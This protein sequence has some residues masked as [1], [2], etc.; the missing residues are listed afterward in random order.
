MNGW[1]E[2]GTVLRL[3]GLTAMNTGNL[4]S[5]SVLPSFSKRK[6]LCLPGVVLWNILIRIWNMRK[7]ILNSCRCCTFLNK[8]KGNKI[9]SPSRRITMNHI[10]RLTRY[11]A[12]FVDEL[13]RR[14]ITDVVIS[15]GSRSTPLAM[16]FTEHPSIKEWVV[17]DERSAAFFALGLAKQSRR[18]VA[19]VCTSGTAAATYFPAV[20]EAYHSRVPLIVLTADRPHEL[21]DIGAPQAIDQIKLF[22]GFVKWYHEMALP[23]ASATMLTYARNRAAQAVH[24]AMEEN[25]GPVHLNLPFREPLTPD[26]TLD[27][28]WDPVGEKMTEQRIT[29]F[30]GKKQLSEGAISLLLRRLKEYK[31]G[32]IVCG[33]QTDPEFKE[34]VTALAEQWQIPVLADPLSQVRCGS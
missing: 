20:V 2:G 4:L 25:Q 6:H 21:R 5:Q 15:P 16:M 12:N 31:K 14:G 26:F 32:V 7:R 19:I 11:T 9:R 8:E 22:G 27:H 10:E 24:N 13:A 17:I 1:T 28:L 30:Q 3:A 18:A 33:P 29:S 23:E 34:A